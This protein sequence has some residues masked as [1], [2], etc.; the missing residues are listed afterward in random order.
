MS[1]GIEQEAIRLLH[2]HEKECAERNIS[3]EG[4]LSKVEAS[5]KHLIAVFYGFIILWGTVELF[6]LN[7]IIK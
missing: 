2:A 6:E 7:Q 5:V 3:T 1:G 4:R